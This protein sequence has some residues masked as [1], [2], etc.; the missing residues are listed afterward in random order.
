MLR[1]VPTFGSLAVSHFRAL[2]N[3]RMNTTTNA[4]AINPKPTRR[5]ASVENIA[6]MIHI[7]IAT[8]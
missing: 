1:A 8:K 6:R 5:L 3:V 7:N 2:R 4:T